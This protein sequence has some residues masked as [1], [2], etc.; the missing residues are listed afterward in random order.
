[1]PDARILYDPLL[2]EHYVGLHHSAMTAA[3]E[4]RGSAG[5]AGAGRPRGWEWV[6]SG[7]ARLPPACLGFGF[8]R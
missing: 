1:M 5:G 8:G 6:G 3:Y 7:L 4:V 2:A